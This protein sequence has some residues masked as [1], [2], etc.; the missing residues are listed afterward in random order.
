MVFNSVEFLLFFPAVCLCYYLIPNKA[1]N[2]FLLAVSCFFYMFWNPRYIVLMAVSTLISWGAALLIEGAG[3]RRRKAWLIL[4]VVINLALLFFFK[5]FN[6]A[7]DTLV[8]LFALIHVELHIPVLDLVLPLGISFYTFQVIGYVADVYR[9]KIRAEHSL[10]RYALFVSF[11]PKLLA[12]P[13]ERSGS[14]LPQL[15]EPHPFRL[16]QVRKGL[17]RMLYGFFQKVVLSGYL[18]IAADTAFDAWQDKT[19]W[20]MLLAMFC[21]TMQIYCDFA[22]YSNLA[23]GSAQVLGFDLMKNFDTPY[24]AVSV[25]DFW[26]RWHISLS[27]WFRDYL[28]I[29]LGGNRKGELRKQANRMIVFLVS[30]LWHGANWHYVVWGGL[31]GLYQ[32]AGDLLKPLRKRIIGLFGIRTEETSHRLMQMGITFFLIS[33]SWVFFRTRSV[34]ES[35]SILLRIFHLDGSEWFTWGNNLTALGLSLATRNVLFLSLLIQLLLDILEYRKVAVDD[36]FLRQGI[37]LRWILLYAAIFGILIFG[38][39]GP[40]Y[41]ASQFI[42][43]QF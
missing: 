43:T 2:V 10:I 41:D 33:I 21:F 6:F 4:A 29:P 38:I 37:W 13:I 39:Y 25:T 36:W 12:G 26:R 14:F 1:K 5:Y 24:F 19:G 27:T 17:L 22:S 7:T 15:Y 28:Y 31:N 42:Y 18:A 20:Q 8:R 35:V 32:T 30:G 23:I 3:D 9:G 34:G 11:F 16:E 40:G